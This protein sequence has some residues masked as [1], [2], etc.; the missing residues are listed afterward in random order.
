MEEG[1]G[2][3][4][5]PADELGAEELLLGRPLERKELVLFVRNSTFAVISPKGRHALAGEEEPKPAKKK[6]PLGFSN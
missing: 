6:R 3:T 1:K 2:L 4:S 5:G